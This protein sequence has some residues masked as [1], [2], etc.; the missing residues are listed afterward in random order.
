MS[1]NIFYHFPSKLNMGPENIK[2]FFV[3]KTFILL[4]TSEKMAM[5]MLVEKSQTDLLLRGGN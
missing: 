2:A 4:V 5:A 3:F 1:S